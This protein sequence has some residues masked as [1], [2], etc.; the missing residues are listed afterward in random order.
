M[1]FTPFQLTF[2]SI[3]RSTFFTSDV[4]RVLFSTIDGGETLPTFNSI[5]LEG[6]HAETNKLARFHEEIQLLLSIVVMPHPHSSNGVVNASFLHYESSYHSTSNSYSRESKH[7]P[8]TRAKREFHS[9]CWTTLFPR[10]LLPP[11]V[12]T[13]SFG[14]PLWFMASSDQ[15]TFRMAG[16]ISGIDSTGFNANKVEERDAETTVVYNFIWIFAINL[17]YQRL[18]T[19]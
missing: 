6:N 10:A 4:I 2:A 5:I 15:N 8:W 3:S 16:S 18:H 13:R 11:L 12:G 7:R 17:L 1:N 9:Y 19:Y 14:I